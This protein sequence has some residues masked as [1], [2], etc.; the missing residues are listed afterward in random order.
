MAFTL[1][2]NTTELLMYR[3]VR[4]ALSSDV[5][6][7]RMHERAKEVMPADK[8][9]EWVATYKVEVLGSKQRKLIERSYPEKVS[10]LVRKDKLSKPFG[11]A[12][13]RLHDFRNEMY[14]RD[15][16]KD[17][18]LRA[19]SIFLFEVV[20]EMFVALPPTSVRSLSSYEE[21][22]SG[23]RRF[24][25]KYGRQG[26]YMFSPEVPLEISKKV[27]G[28]ISISLNRLR[29]TL[30]KH[31][32]ARLVQTLENLEQ[33]RQDGLGNISTAK[34]LKELQFI[35]DQIVRDAPVHKRDL[36]KYSPKFRMT[37]FAK[38]KRAIRSLDDLTDKY[39]LFNRFTTV[40]REFLEMEEVIDLAARHV[41][42]AVQHA[43]DVARG[44]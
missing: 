12:L 35:E 15:H 13:V 18:L 44:K 11:E 19:C 34:A 4:R 2:D 39:L 25:R 30:K 8:Y 22:S 17:D 16:V 38:W 43:I 5:Y 31:L 41:D 26:F 21:E 27:R 40:E 24:Q 6:L 20:C 3:S 36:K 9:A 10:Y 28:S 14:H 1:L 32:K 29:Q 33:V 42:E 7:E 23:W 37:D